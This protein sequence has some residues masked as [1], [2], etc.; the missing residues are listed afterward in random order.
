MRVAIIAASL[1][2]SACATPAQQASSGLDSRLDAMIGQPVEVAVARLGAPIASAPMGTDTLYGWGHA[3]TST[4]ILSPLPDIAAGASAQS[5][6]F[7]PPRRAV[8]NDCIIRAV[9]SAE[10]QIRAWDYQGNDRGCRYYAD[11]LA[12]SAMARAG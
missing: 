10:G 3:F 7:P 9:V 4:E 2:L 5:G 6:V 1:A 11:R 12:G 8:Q